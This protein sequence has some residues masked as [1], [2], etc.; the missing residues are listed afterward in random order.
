MPRILILNPNTTASVTEL[1]TRH[2]RAV[3]GDTIECVPA[4]A[5]FGANYISNE[6]AYAIAGHSALDGVAE[7][8]QGCD[9]VL[10]ACFGDPGLFALREVSDAP[11]VGL[12]EASMRAAAR[13]AGRFSIVTG[14]ERWG[15]IL[16]RLAQALGYADALAGIRTIALTGAQAAADPDAAVGVLADECRAARDQAGGGAVILGGAGFAGLAARVTPLAGFPIIDSVLAGAR[17]AEALCRGAAWSYARSAPSRR[18]DTIGLEATLAAKF[19][20]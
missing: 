17:E 11:V 15:P 16:E 1:V 10:L 20:D 14:G 12:A 5:R 7:Y 6:A 13:E 18:V 2:A 8:G 4:T 9:A 19:A 3:L